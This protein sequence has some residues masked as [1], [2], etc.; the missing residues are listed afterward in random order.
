M[1]HIDE[2]SNTSG[3]FR[4]ELLENLP[5]S[6][7][8]RLQHSQS[9]V[10]KEGK[11]AVS[12]KA[13]ATKG[14]LNDPKKAA[15]CVPLALTE[16]SGEAFIYDDMEPFQITPEYG[17]TWVECI[18]AIKYYM[19]DAICKKLK[20]FRSDPQQV[21][22]KI[23]QDWKENRLLCGQLLIFG[24]LKDERS[25][26]ERRK[27]PVKWYNWWHCA[28]VDLFK[29]RYWCAYHGEMQIEIGLMKFRSISAVVGF[30][31]G[32]K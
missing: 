20:G 29:D 2:E 16:L 30:E 22:S 14:S 24:I 32:N 11:G 28:A 1:S 25:E 23:I 21:A 17:F 5:A 4:D 15:M 9:L 6:K 12:H 7:R 31:R 18:Q 8:P 13:T 10:R 27:E 19:D 26:E 3:D